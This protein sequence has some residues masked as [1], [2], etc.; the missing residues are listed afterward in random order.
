M[1]DWSRL[2]NFTEAEFRC[3][4]TG[5]C[6]M[7]AAFM[8]REG[9]SRFYPRW[10]LERAQPPYHRLTGCVERAQPAADRHTRRLERTGHGG[11]DHAGRRLDR[12]QLFCCIGHRRVAGLERRFSQAEIDRRQD[13]ITATNLAAI[14]ESLNDI[15]TAL[16]RL[17]SQRER[18]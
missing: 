16:V 7:D 4:H 2:P 11:P 13:E 5:K 14:R 8:D 3:K 17:Q 6:D 12:S 9:I 18:P 10:Q 15:K 1:L